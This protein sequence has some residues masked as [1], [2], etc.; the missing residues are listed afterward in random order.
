[1]ETIQYDEFG[2]TIGNGLL[3][4]FAQDRKGRSGFQIRLEQVII[5]FGNPT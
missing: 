4:G 3:T 5:R 2:D 1:M